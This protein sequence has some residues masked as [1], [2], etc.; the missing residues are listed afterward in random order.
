MIVIKKMATAAIGANKAKRSW[1]L[2]LK[3]FHQL[4]HRA[5]KVMS[6]LFCIGV[7]FR[8]ALLITTR[9]KILHYEID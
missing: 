9:K 3:R 4:R 8:A 7:E 1:R 2:G 5:L 6:K